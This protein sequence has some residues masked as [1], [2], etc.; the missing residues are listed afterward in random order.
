MSS[1]VI[2]KRQFEEFVEDRLVLRK[3]SIHNVIK[4]NLPLMSVEKV[5]IKSK[6]KQNIVDLR[7]D[8]TLFYK[9]YVAS[10]ARQIDAKKFF[11]HENSSC[12]SSTSDLGKL[13]KP[14]NKSD[15]VCCI[16]KSSG[17]SPTTVYEPN[18]SCVIID[19]AAALVH[20]LIPQSSQTFQ[21]YCDQIVCPYVFMRLKTAD[22]VDLVFDRYLE[23]R[24][25][26]DTRQLRG[27]GP[28]VNVKSNVV[29]PKSFRLTEKSKK[30]S[31]D[32]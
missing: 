22:R 2:G 4:I 9:L 32:F 28:R 15:V 27:S 30:I 6:D 19:G 1:N 5:S 20:M 14:S 23:E 31:S 7:K 24:L 10:Q 26:N 21:Q 16:L 17:V 29:I 25:K 18:V 12:L 3:V 11:A 8:S 13:R